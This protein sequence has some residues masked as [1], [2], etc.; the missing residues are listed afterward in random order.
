MLALSPHIGRAC[1]HITGQHYSTNIL[2][3]ALTPEDLALLE[4]HFV[5]EKL[6]R[7]LVLI[8]ANQPIQYAWFPEGGVVSI[9]AELSN[10]GSTEV[11]IFGREGFAGTPLLLGANTTLHHVY[12]QIGGGTGL[13]IEASHLVA[14][15]DKSPALRS[16]FLRYIQTFMTQTAYSAVS[17]AHQRIKGVS[18]A[19]CSCAM[20][21][22]TE[23][24]SRLPMS[25]W[26]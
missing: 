12:V 5:R 13:R 25:S 15:T 7:E 26:L 18:R 16:V 22:K 14:A 6:E 9:V 20:I 2:L 23:I 24:R 3:R 1:M 11:G 21:A 8:S 10:S 19:G 17:N 4:P